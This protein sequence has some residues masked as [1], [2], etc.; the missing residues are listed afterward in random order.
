MID[1]GRYNETFGPLKSNYKLDF[2][3]VRIFASRM[4]TFSYTKH[5]LNEPVRIATSSGS[6]PD[7]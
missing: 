2:G 3:G 5:C 7:H 4:V 1:S 6:S